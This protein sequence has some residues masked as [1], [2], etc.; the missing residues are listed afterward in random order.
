MRS[1]WPFLLLTLA[2]LVGLAFPARELNAIGV[3]SAG[4]LPEES[5]TR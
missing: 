3:G 5:K 1:P 4:S 2:I